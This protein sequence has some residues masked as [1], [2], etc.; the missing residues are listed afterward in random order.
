MKPILVQVLPGRGSFLVTAGLNMH[1]AGPLGGHPVA[2]PTQA[3]HQFDA[4]L[5][6]MGVL[7]MYYCAFDCIEYKIITC[8]LL[9]SP[10]VWVARAWRGKV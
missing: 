3:N 8:M 1:N 4:Q 2:N 10:T 6:D 9:S 5:F 7:L